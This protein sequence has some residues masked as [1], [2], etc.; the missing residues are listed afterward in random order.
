MKNKC[1][2]CKN[3]IIKG[4]KKTCIHCNTKVVYGEILDSFMEYCSFYSKINLKEKI[5]EF[6]NK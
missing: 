5:K 6:V 4:N 2:T 1:E 3:L